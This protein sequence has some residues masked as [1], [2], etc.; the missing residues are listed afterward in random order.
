MIKVDPESKIIF[1]MDCWL[2]LTGNTGPYLQYTYARICSL[3]EKSKDSVP[4]EHLYSN[5][6]KLERLS[7]EQ[8]LSHLSGFNDA[9]DIAN[10]KLKPSYFANYTYELAKKFNAFYVDSPI[11]QES[12]YATMSARLG[13]VKINYYYLGSALDILGI[14][15]IEK[16]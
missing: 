5:A 1:N 12:D 15:R 2:N 14:P 13:L 8:L 6:D 7:E 9:V 11:A 3:L 16:I 4:I 10:K